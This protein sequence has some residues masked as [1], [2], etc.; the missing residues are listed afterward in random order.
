MSQLLAAS[1]FLWNLKKEDRKFE[2][3]DIARVYGV[4]TTELQ[5]ALN[6]RIEDELRNAIKRRGDGK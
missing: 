5:K 2:M 1:N 4:N 6:K 3:R